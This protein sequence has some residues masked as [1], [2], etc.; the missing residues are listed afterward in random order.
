MTKLQKALELNPRSAYAHYNLGLAFS[1]QGRT[2]LAKAQFAEALRIDPT[3]SK[4]RV[5][6]EQAKI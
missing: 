5:R 3:L 4:A 1:K 2:D 6:L